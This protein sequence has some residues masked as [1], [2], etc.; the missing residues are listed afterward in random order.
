MVD[1]RMN[2]GEKKVEA[3]VISLG[4]TKLSG[5]IA[6]GMEV[7]RS[8]AEMRHEIEQLRQ[9]IACLRRQNADMQE[10]FAAEHRMR[11]NADIECRAKSRALMEVRRGQMGAWSQLLDMSSDKTLK[12]RKFTTVVMALTALGAIALVLMA[13]VVFVGA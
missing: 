8:R 9:E 4:D 2:E 6:E 12:H 11:V 10:H 13:I 1:Q 5:A 7:G 3:R